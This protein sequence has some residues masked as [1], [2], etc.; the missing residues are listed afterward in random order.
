V[1]DRW[2]RYN[3][4]RAEKRFNEMAASA[5]SEYANIFA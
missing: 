4:G 2:S 3:T 1:I 5:L